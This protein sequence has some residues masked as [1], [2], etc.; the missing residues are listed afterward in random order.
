[1]HVF[2]EII[3]VFPSIIAFYLKSDNNP[4]YIIVTS[5]SK[6]VKNW[7]TFMVDLSQ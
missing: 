1:M 4:L 5:Q 2:T 7:L 3:N 6:W